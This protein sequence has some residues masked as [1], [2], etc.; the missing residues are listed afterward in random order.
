MD[1]LHQFEVVKLIPLELLGYDVSLTNAA[2]FMAIAA[3]SIILFFSLA[4]RAHAL[5]PGRMQ[6]LAESIYEFTT[7]LVEENVGSDG[8]PFVPLIL[9][10]FTF[11]LMGNLLGMIPGAFTFTSQLIVTFALASFVFVVMIIAGMVRHGLGFLRLFFPS[12]IPLAL[13]P[14]LVPIELISFL[15]RPISLSVRL[16]ANM[17]AGHTMLKVFAGFS[18]LLGMWGIAPLFLTILLT[19][20]EV[21]VAVLQAYVFAVLSCIYLKDAVHSH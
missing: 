2:L 21:L 6:A 16:F 14:F 20:F 8:A 15:S 10:I 12:G 3:F 19:L 9:T 17:M 5:L 18:V 7:G 13:A 4:M 11:I 1:P